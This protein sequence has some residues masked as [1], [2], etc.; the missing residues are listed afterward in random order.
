[1]IGRITAI[2]REEMNAIGAEELMMPALVARE[3]WQKSGRWETDVM[4]KVGEEKNFGLGWT[5][6]EVMTA[7]A[8]RFISS[9]QDLPRAAYQIQTK[10]RN[11]PR[12]R[13]GLLRGREFLM[14]DLYSFHADQ[15]DLF[16][17][18]DRV[19]EAYWKII[20][21]MGLEKFTKLTEAS[22]GEFTKEYTHEFQVFS[23]AGEDA[24]IHCGSCDFAQNKEIAAGLES[25]PCPKCGGKLEESSA[26]EVAN[27]FKLGTRYS[28]PFG[29]SYATAQGAKKPVVMGSYGIGPSRLMGTLAEVMSDERGLVWPESVAP[30]RVHLLALGKASANGLYSDLTERGIEVLHDDRDI[31]PGQKLVE[32]DLLGIPYR[33]VV[34]EKTAGKV[35]L[36]RRAAGEVEL[37]ASEALA[38][39]LQG[40]S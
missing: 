32:A 33:A 29:L 4:Y 34:S 19:I 36:K 22:G 21:R 35:E 40:S 25:K 26:I 18:Y 6:E 7:I 13:S 24:V 39:I 31:S 38:K 3:Y 28:E 11:E 15:E 30:F 16:G 17:Y 14:K 2:I 8:T 23:E 9:Y 27:V 12:A 1:M 5:H 10:F 37:V 20:R